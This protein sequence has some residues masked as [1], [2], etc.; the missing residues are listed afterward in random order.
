MLGGVLAPASLTSGVDANGA[1]SALTSALGNISLIGGLISATGFDSTLGTN[2]KASQAD[3]TRTIKANAV[4]VLD[5]GALLNGLGLPLNA[6]PIDAVSGILD[7][8]GLPVASVVS[9]PLAP[10]S[11]ASSATLNTTL[12][13]LQAQLAGAA[14]GIHQTA[15]P[16][17]ITSLLGGL[18]L[19]GL[20]IPVIGDP[21]SVV[22][23][24]IDTVQ[25]LLAGVLETA[26]SASGRREPPVG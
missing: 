20:P 6:L 5:L 17:P 4:N 16:A 26:L 11:A 2:A 14:G 19:G 25:G 22:N 24:L 23:A 9:R 1:H 15:L 13:G 10:T 7:G 8:L 18:P 3:G 21:L 12:D